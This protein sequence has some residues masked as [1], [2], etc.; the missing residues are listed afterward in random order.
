MSVVNT[1]LE[2]LGLRSPGQVLLYSVGINRYRSSQLQ[3]CVNDSNNI[4]TYL[5]D[6]GA[7]V[8]Q[9][10]DEQAT[11]SNMARFWQEGIGRVGPRDLLIVHYSG[12]GSEGP[13]T[14]E[15]DRTDECLVS[16]DMK[17]FWDNDMGSLLSRVHPYGQAVVLLDCCHSQTATRE[18]LFSSGVSA[19]SI[20]FSELDYVP[21]RR[22]LSP[23][24]KDLAEARNWPIVE[25][26]ACESNDV[27][28]DAPQPDG[29]VQGCYT[30]ALIDSATEL[31]AD[32]TWLSR[33]YTAKTLQARIR[34]KLPSEDYPNRPQLLATDWQQRWVMWKP[35]RT[36]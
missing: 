14:T 20:P 15:I 31:D 3:G 23:T 7:E 11:L 6:R 19:R 18:F 32:Q 27:T 29:T 35:D 5:K 30:R 33:G 4:A 26:A 13:S 8:N 36:R 28:Y 2:T 12:H 21:A 24:T 10:L 34:T 17:P 25:F 9:L 1:V 16:Q 22:A